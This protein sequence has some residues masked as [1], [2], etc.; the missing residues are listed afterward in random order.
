MSTEPKP[1]TTI[2]RNESE[3]AG[4]KFYGPLADDR[5]ELTYLRD[6]KRWAEDLRVRSR[7]DA[8]TLRDR[9][10]LRYAVARFAEWKGNLM[11]EDYPEFESWVEEANVAL[12]KLGIRRIKVEK[13]KAD[14]RETVEYECGGDYCPHRPKCPTI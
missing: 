6:W 8:L 4:R 14:L 1:W 3:Y 2:A 9:A 12:E 13:E 11:P 5:A 7:A 10:A